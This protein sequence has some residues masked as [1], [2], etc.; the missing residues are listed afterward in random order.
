MFLE[1]S[2]TLCKPRGKI[3][4]VLPK[5]AMSQSLPVLQ[6]LFLAVIRSFV[7]SGELSL[8]HFL[9]Q[10]CWVPQLMFEQS[11]P[12]VNTDGMTGSLFWAFSLALNISIP[13]W[14]FS[15]HKPAGYNQEGV[16]GCK[17]SWAA[18][19]PILVLCTLDVCDVLRSR[20]WAPLPPGFPKHCRA[21]AWAE[22]SLDKSKLEKSS[23]CQAESCPQRM[24]RWLPAESC[25]SKLIPA[26]TRMCVPW[27]CTPTSAACSP[28]CSELRVQMEPHKG[29]GLSF[30]GWHP[31]LPK[32]LWDWAM[33]PVK[34]LLN[35]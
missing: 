23:C 16:K 31:H 35:L 18:Q 1:N 27:A 6:L 9:Q 25:G 15:L 4:S 7:S 24:C 21:S 34:C 32:V 3:Q 14:T 5:E 22:L 33:I 30:P 2:L 19:F 13:S 10:L 20:E 8:L 28:S 29:P 11:W 26:S 12:S 17:K